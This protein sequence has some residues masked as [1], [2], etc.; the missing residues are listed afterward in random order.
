MM[1]IARSH[2][3]VRS[4]ALAG[5]VSAL[6]TA[7][8]WAAEPFETFT[9]R[10][11]RDV[12]PADMIQGEHYRLAP[13]VRTFTFLNDFIAS[14]DYGVF[15]AQSDAMLRRLIREIHAIA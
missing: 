9:P 4:L 10:P 12:L 8:A 1:S 13:T 11:V 15:E 7:A 2:R 3:L 14:S 5:L 6:T